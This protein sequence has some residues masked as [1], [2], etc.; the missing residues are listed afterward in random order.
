MLEIETVEAS[1]YNKWGAL[2]FNF[3]VLATNFKDGEGMVENGAS[4][5]NR[6]TESVAAPSK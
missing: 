2:C 3:F 1:Q 5:V 4:L 6:P